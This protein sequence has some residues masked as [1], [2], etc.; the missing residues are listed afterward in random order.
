MT[1]AYLTLNLYLLLS[2]TAFAQ[3]NDLQTKVLAKERQGLDCLKTGNLAEFAALTAEDAIFVDAHG[4]ANKA[5]VLKNTSEFR[6]TDYTIEDVHFVP[7]SSK[8]GLVTYKITESGTS[9]GKQFSA[10]VYVS[11]I[12][13]ERKGKWL[14]LFSQETSAR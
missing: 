3:P 6:L 2:F 11:S 5:Q 8:S 13:A 9:H 10:K 12:W 14:C 1:K 7:L 4:P